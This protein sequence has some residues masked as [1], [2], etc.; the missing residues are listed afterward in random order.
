MRLVVSQFISLDGVIEAPGGGEDVPFAGWSFKFDRGPEGDQFKLD[1]LEA[2]DA[3]LLGRLTYEGYAAVWPHLDD[4][5]GFARRFN[6][7]RKYVVSTTL[8]HPEWE[9]STVLSTDIPDEVAKLRAEAGN[10]L[11]LNGSATLVQTLIEHDLVDEY[12]LMVFPTVLGAG[13]RLFQEPSSVPALRLLESRPLGPDG[14]VLLRY[15]P[16]R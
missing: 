16:V 3:L 9:H 8:E 5:A 4:E 6:A 13:K 15:E 7:I 10:D 14:I 11:Q 2:T 12:R 1:E